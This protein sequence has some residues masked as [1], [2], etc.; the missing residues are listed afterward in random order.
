MTQ[1]TASEVERDKRRRECNR[2]SAVKC[3]TMVNE[4]RKRNEQVDLIEG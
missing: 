4:Q 3:R 2:R 1:M